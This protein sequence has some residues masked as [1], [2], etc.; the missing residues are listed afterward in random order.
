MKLTNHNPFRV[1]LPVSQLEWQTAADVANHLLAIDTGRAWGLLD[2]DGR[3]NTKRCE[4]ILAE[5]RTRL[6]QPRTLGPAGPGQ[7]R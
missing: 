4:M 7:Q 5:A 3:T 1:R 6:I 2:D